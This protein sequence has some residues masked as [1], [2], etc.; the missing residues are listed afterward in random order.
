MGEKCNMHGKVR[1][2]YK[3]SVRKPQGK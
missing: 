3:I 2:T 1:H